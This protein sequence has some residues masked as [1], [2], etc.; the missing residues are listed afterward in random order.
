MSTSSEKPTIFVTRRWPDAAED[1][2]KQ[3]FKPTLMS[4]TRR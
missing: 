3:Y 1:A 2:L 4:M